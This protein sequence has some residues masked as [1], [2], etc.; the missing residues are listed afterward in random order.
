M[1]YLREGHEQFLA[2][3]N[4]KRPPPWRMLSHGRS[5]RPAEPARWV[6][7]CVCA[8]VGDA[9]AGWTLFQA[10]QWQDECVTDCCR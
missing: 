2:A 4:D 3:T 5:I 9:V 1:V 8:V 6:G 7:A 10:L